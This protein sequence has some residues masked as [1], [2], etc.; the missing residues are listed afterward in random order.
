MSL[1][2][3]DSVFRPGAEFKGEKIETDKYLEWIHGLHCVKQNHQ[4]G[5]KTT[6]FPLFYNGSWIEAACP[7]WTQSIPIT[8]DTRKFDVLNETYAENGYKQYIVENA[9]ILLSPALRW[10][11]PEISCAIVLRQLAGIIIGVEASNVAAIDAFLDQFTGL[12]EYARISYQIAAS[13]RTLDIIKQF[14]KTKAD[15]KNDKMFYAQFATL[16]EF[17]AASRG[18]IRNDDFLCSPFLS[19]QMGNPKFLP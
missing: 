4:V 5:V 19:Y 13:T 1:L 6:K 16:L 8:T 14:Q 12:Q 2:S 18:L 17:S 7:H 11:E 3:T 10:M 9:Y 15:K